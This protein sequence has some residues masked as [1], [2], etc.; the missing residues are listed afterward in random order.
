MGRDKFVSSLYAS[1]VSIIGSHF[2]LIANA[3][4][5]IKVVQI[6][7]QL[8][9]QNITIKENICTYIYVKRDQLL[10]KPPL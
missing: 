4:K 10:T 7:W 6:V 5:R 1:K 2:R 9:E 8:Y 3:E